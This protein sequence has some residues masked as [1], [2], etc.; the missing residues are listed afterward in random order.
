MH[1]TTLSLA[2]T[3]ILLL[4]PE[5]WAQ[6]SSPHIGYVFPAG[7]Q[8][9]TT[10]EVKLGGQY[11]AEAVAVEVSG[12]GVTTKILRQT[13][14]LKPSE[15][16]ALR[17]KLQDLNEKVRKT[18]ADKKEIA[19]IR[20][21]LAQAAIPVNPVLG[22]NVFVEVTIAMNAAPGPREL[23][24]QAKTGMSN[25]VVFDV[26]SLPEVRQKKE[27][28][29]PEARPR[30]ALARFVKK[31]SIARESAV[32]VSLPIVLNSQ[33]MP[34]EVDHYRFTAK[35]GQ[36]LVF[37]TRARALM[38]YLADAVPGWIQAALTLYDADGNE[39]A[40][41][42]DFGDSPDPVLDY[43]V[44]SDGEYVLEIHDALYRGREDF[45]Y[46]IEAGELPHI[47]SVFPLGGRAG[48]QTT[49]SLEGW[50]LPRPSL[51][52]EA[53]EMKP[54]KIPLSMPNGELWSNQVPFAVNTLPEIMEQEPNNLIATAQRITMPIVVNGRIDKP[55][56]V[57]LFRFEGQAGKVI[58]AEVWARRLGSPLDSYLKL[59]DAAGKTLAFNDDQEDRGQGLMTHHADSRIQT[60][61]PKDGIYYLQIGDI[62]R[63]GSR[64]HAYRLR[65]SPPRPDFELRITPC[66]INARPGTTVPVTVHALRKDGFA[67]EINLFLTYRPVGF[68]LAGAKIPA[69]QNEVRM[70]V[71]VPPTPRPRAVQLEVEGRATIAG[72]LVSHPATPA[73]D[74]M[75]AFAYHHLVPADHLLV[76]VSKG[77][78]ARFPA[79]LLHTQPIKIRPGGTAIV[80]FAIP[81]G[82]ASDKLQVILN[83]PPEGI[84][85]RRSVFEGDSAILELRADSEKVK[86]GLRTNVIAEVYPRSEKGGKP[87]RFPLGTFPAIPVEVIRPGR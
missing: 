66:S 58:V 60:T 6:V 84:S 83:E 51:T 42:D 65:V 56:D 69:N 7:G 52:L 74:M 50:N 53:K 12:T 19:A 57:D 18:P 40:F 38:P 79:R 23:R 35:K 67:G 63:H 29:D 87:S 5:S 43:K 10:F 8:H 14:P 1:R 76:A 11:F 26:G 2:L 86:P 39:V 3:A 70:T 48:V 31:R 22:D 41:N 27:S 17:K 59:T 82:A 34:G 30:P 54:G 71:Q 24:L 47:T 15:I 4:T 16:E 55:G 77:A 73:E 46:R 81:R 78:R 72:K 32:K 20:E 80:R 37:R 68:A 25:P 64:A 33:L 9:G 49:V 45:V 36:H 62:R 75:Q 61:L 85:L 13:T 28:F 21:Q 44:P